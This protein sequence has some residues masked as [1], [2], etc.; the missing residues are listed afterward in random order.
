MADVEHARSELLP[1]TLEMLILR[2]LTLGPRHGYG[3]AR[4]IEQSSDGSLR[5]E[6]GSLYPALERLLRS[7]KVTASW[8]KSPTGR[9]ARFYKITRSGRAALKEKTSEYDRVI[10]AIERIMSEA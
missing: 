8:S 4:H 9:R 3:I 7:G 5:I 1:G 6:Q 10:S 2:T